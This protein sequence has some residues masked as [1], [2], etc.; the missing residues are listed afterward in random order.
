MHINPTLTYRD[1]HAFAVID[2]VT[3]AKLLPLELRD[4]AIIASYVYDP[5]SSSFKSNLGAGEPLPLEFF[6][7]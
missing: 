7:G 1:G 3:I 2:N 4:E 6:N 5:Q